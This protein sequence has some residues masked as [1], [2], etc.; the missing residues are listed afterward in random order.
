[1]CFLRDVI[2]S[3]DCKLVF[4]LARTKPF[5]PFFKGGSG[6]VTICNV[7]GEGDHMGHTLY[8]QTNQPKLYYVLAFSESCYSYNEAQLKSVYI[9]QT[10]LSYRM[11]FSCYY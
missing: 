1:M 9:G 8:Q 2:G 7:G 11:P 3:L 5:S 10:S 4:R 6:G